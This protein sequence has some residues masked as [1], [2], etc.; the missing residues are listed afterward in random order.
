MSGAIAT[1]VSLMFLA[2]TREI[3]QGFFGLFKVGAESEAVHVTSIVWAV[4][5][6]YILDFSI[7]TSTYRFVH[8]VLNHSH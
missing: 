7:N 6:I 1:I 8:V 5:F 3:V 4:S 2:W